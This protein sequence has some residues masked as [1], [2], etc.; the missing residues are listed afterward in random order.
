MKH[1]LLAEYHHLLTLPKKARILQISFALQGAAYPILSTFMSAFIW[2]QEGGLINV[3]FYHLGLFIALPIV[4]YLNGTLLVRFSITRLYLYGSLLMAVSAIILVLFSQLF[5]LVGFIYALVGFI[6][7]A[8]NG[9]HWANRNYLTQKETESSCRAYFIGLNLT[10]DTIT[11]IF[12]PLIAGWTIVTLEHAFNLPLIMSYIPLVLFAVLLL[13]TSGILVEKERFASPKTAL[14]HIQLISPSWRA[15]RFLTVS[16]G[17][18]EGVTFYL[19]TI[20][21][22]EIVGNEGVLGTLTSLLAFV[23]MALTY[24][25]GRK[26]SITHHVPV[27]ILSQFVGMIAGFFVMIAFNQFGVMLYLLLSTISFSFLWIASEPIMMDIVDVEVADN[28]PIRYAYILDREVFLNIGRV[29]S[30]SIVLVIAFFINMQILFR[31]SL[32][33]VFLTSILMAPLWVSTLS[34]KNKQK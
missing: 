34:I 13:I 2:R 11:S 26:A 5:V 27:L 18:I 29:L 19:P 32:V 33:S 17:I 25:Y 20:L 4:F 8:G 9:F 22:L 7:G 3:A 23:G 31:Y 6:D 1:R 21:I 15:M 30:V 12:V 28:E 10:V 24:S 14:L 16:L